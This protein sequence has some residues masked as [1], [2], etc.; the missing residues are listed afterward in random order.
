MPPTNNVMCQSRC[1]NLIIISRLNETRRRESKQQQYCVK[2]K[3]KFS[4]KSSKNNSRE[5]L[6]KCD[7]EV[8]NR[9]FQV[10][11]SKAF[12]KSSRGAVGLYRK[13]KSDAV[14][15]KGKEKSFQ[16]V[17]YTSKYKNGFS[18]RVS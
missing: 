5:M 11:S 3:N 8:N 17:L 16:I 1:S 13:G 7:V 14:L 12:A 4:L 2:E 18:Y 9:L 6:I 15:Q 10:Q